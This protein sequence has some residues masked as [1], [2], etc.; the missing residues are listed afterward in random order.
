MDK[1]ITIFIIA[2]F[3]FFICP[4]AI[5]VTALIADSRARRHDQLST[6]P[7]TNGPTVTKRRST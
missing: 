4:I 6:G 3:M 5:M 2:V 7:M 1:D